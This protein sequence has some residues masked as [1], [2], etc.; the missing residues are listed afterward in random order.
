MRDVRKYA[1]IDNSILKV[2]LHLT[3]RTKTYLIRKKSPYFLTSSLSSRLSFKREATMV[4]AELGQFNSRNYH[5]GILDFLLSYLDHHNLKI[6]KSDYC[7]LREDKYHPALSVEISTGQISMLSATSFLGPTEYIFAV[8]K[9]LKYFFFK[10]FPEK[11]P[12]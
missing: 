12:R 10:Y 11:F 2:G 7:L 1:L 5:G 4:Y 9:I 8:H 3:P 6:F